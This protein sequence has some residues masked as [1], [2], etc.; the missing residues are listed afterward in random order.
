MAKLE[1][2]VKGILS[3]KKPVT[4]ILYDEVFL[5]FG[6]AVKDNPNVFDQNRVYLGASYEAIKNIKLSV[7]YIWGYQERNSGK[8]FDNI[9]T[10]WTILTLDN[11][12]SQFLHHKTEK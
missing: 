8:E 3:D 7:G 9:N 10:F 12:I 11:F 5:Q 6:G 2:P 1:K 4:L